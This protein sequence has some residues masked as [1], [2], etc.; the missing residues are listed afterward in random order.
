METMPS[1]SKRCHPLSKGKNEQTKRAHVNHHFNSYAMVG[2]GLKMPR[3]RN[4]KIANSH[5]KK[6]IN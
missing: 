6:K 2:D 5:K 4:W 1:L 3:T